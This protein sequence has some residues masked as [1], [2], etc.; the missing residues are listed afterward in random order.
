M[1][2]IPSGL[3]RFFVSARRYLQSTQQLDSLFRQV[4]YMTAAH[5][6]SLSGIRHDLSVLLRLLSAW[7]RGEYRGIAWQTLILIA[8]SL[9]YLVIPLDS[10]PDFV[11]GLGL[12]DDVAVITYVVERLHDDI[13][14]FERWESSVEVPMI[15][16]E[17][18][19]A[20]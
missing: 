3:Q 12:L 17:T 19:E 1:A 11:A 7:R 15:Y 13:S 16:S 8:A 10:V 18:S 20:V 5:A 14:E 6:R 9:L 2:R 4:Q